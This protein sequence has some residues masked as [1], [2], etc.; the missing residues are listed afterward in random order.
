MSA[1]LYGVAVQWKL[2]LRSRSLLV[3]CYVVPLLFFL[4]MGGIFTTVMPDMKRTLI[5]AMM[6]MGVS[7]GAFIGLPPSL[8]ETYGSDIKKVY[9]ANG[10][11]LSLGVA[12]MVLSTLTHLMIMCAVIL[13]LAPILFDAVLPANLPSFFVALFIFITASLGIGS[14]LGLAVKSQAKLTMMTQLAF[15]PSLMLSGTMFPIELLPKAF[16]L[17]GRAFPAFWGYRLMQDG[18][19]QFANLWYLLVVFLLAVAGC[20]LLLNRK[21]SQ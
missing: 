12:T 9:R 14:I 2:D 19:F 21:K 1:F 6:V 17:A 18:G 20:G 4:L 8:I 7:M 13:L 11:P 3:T 10:V 16:E 5:P 15:L